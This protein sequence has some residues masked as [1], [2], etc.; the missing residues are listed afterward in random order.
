MKRTPLR[1]PSTPLRILGTAAAVGLLAAPVV[2]GTLGAE[3]Q[4]APAP[5]FEVASIKP[6]NSGDGRVM[7]QNQPG[8]F[9]TGKWLY[10]GN[11][12]LYKA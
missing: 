1:T 10:S 8:R 7:M 4:Q 2:V 5:A 9:I 3:A 12:R 11:I 6:N